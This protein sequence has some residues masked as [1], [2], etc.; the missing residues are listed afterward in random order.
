MIQ[1]MMHQQQQHMMHQQ[2]QQQ[3]Q[4]SEHMQGGSKGRS[5]SRMRKTADSSSEGA[6]PYPP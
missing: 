1:H 4:G 5:G 6:H 3:Q 2:Q